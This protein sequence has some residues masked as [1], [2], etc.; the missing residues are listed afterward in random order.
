MVEGMNLRSTVNNVDYQVCDKGKI[1]RQPFKPSN[2][3]SNEK[4]GLVHS[5]ICGPMRTE[6]IGGAKYFV[7][8][9]DDHTRYTET[10]MLRNKSDVLDAFRKYKQRNEKQTGCVIK[11]L[12]TD[13]AKE[14]L[15]REFSKFLQ[16]NGPRCDAS[17]SMSLCT[18][19]E[20]E[21]LK[22]MIPGFGGR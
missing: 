20:H 1:C 17:F 11:C 7:T 16:G 10:M 12:R 9:I 18:V 6:S 15:S 4:L 2:R 8:F 3:K 14:Y 21:K 13:N 22:R 19:V 5:D